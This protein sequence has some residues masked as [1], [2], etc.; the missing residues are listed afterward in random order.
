MNRKNIL[1]L[2]TLITIGLITQLNCDSKEFNP[3]RIAK[4]STQKTI[5]TD[6]DYKREIVES[7]DN[8][9]YT[10][11]NMGSIVGP[12]ELSEFIKK[13][14]SN[15]SIYTPSEE[16]VKN[17]VFRANFHIHT[18]NSDGE[19]G[20]EELLDSAAAYA[21]ANGNRP[22]YFAIT[23]HNTVN[24]LKTAV[25][26]LQ[27]NPQKY[28]NIKLI[29][30]ME[31]FSSLE[32][33]KNTMKNPIDIHVLCWAI[34][35]YD[36]ELNRVFIKKDLTDKGNRT[37]RTF[38]NAINLLKNKG[39]VGIAHPMRYVKNDNMVKDKYNYYAY[40]LNKY[41]RLNKG[42]TLFAEGYYQSYQTDEDKELVDAINAEFKKKNIIRTGSTDSHGH[43]I[44]RK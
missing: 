8:S 23:D 20:V 27:K 26:I 10:I 33:E 44:F 15:P 1:I 43:S 22:F 16:N 11:E 7:S 19:F 9:T 37:Y 5:L 25:D 36:E 13:N 6:K 34:N 40:L 24:G 31:V 38:D 41:A 29:L 12:I 14:D 42:H 3:N 17:G 18:V 30:G 35:P 21:A 2:L 39:I 4:L 28:K 32:A